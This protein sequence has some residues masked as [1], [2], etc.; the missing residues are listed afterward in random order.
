MKTHQFFG[1]PA[2]SSGIASACIGTGTL[3]ISTPKERPKKM[4][5]GKKNSQQQQ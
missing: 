4:E 1:F 3:A 5:N 2:M